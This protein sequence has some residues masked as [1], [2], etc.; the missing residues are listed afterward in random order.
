MDVIGKM[1]GLAVLIMFAVDCVV[2]AARSSLAW[3]RIRRVGKKPRFRAGSMLQLRTRQ[4]ALLAALAAALCLAAVDLTTLRIAETIRKGIVPEQLDIVL[5]WIVLV[6]GIDRTKELLQRFK[7]VAD[8]AG[9]RKE[10]PAVR[11]TVD[12]KDGQIHAV[13]KAVANA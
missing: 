3:E 12:N 11:V 9:E 13:P 4:N 1:I 6:A 7:G 2:S 8:S 5:T 10:T